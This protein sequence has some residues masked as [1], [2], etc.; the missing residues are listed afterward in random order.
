LL[1]FLPSLAFLSVA[2][3]IWSRLNWKY[4]FL[5]RTFFFFYKRICIGKAVTFITYDCFVYQK[6][7]VT[8]RRNT[9][10]QF[11]FNDSVIFSFMFNCNCTVFER[12]LMN[13]NY[14]KYLDLNFNAVITEPI[15]WILLHIYIHSFILIT[16]YSTSKTDAGLFQRMCIFNMSVVW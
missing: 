14:L 9:M 10:E 4:Y 2:R 16:C 1:F 12:V 15:T 3:I 6:N 13:S 8:V 7:F 5:S 11:N